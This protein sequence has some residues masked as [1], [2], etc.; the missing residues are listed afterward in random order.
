MLWIIIIGTAVAFIV[1]VGAL[2]LFA[3]CKAAGMEITA[4]FT[5]I[6]EPRSYSA[7]EITEREASARRAKR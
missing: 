5:D 3:L 4:V 1:A 7:R 2:F 6:D